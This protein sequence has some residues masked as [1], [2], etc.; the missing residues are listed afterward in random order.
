MLNASWDNCSVGWLERISWTP[1][2]VGVVT[3]LTILIVLTVAGN[4]LV[5]AA[6]GKKRRLRSSAGLLILSLATADL[7]VGVLILPF[8]AAHELMGF[9]W[10]FGAIPCQL[11]LS[12][13]I[14][15]CTASI[16]NLVVISIDR[17][18]AIIKPL[19]YPLIV[20][21]NRAKMI[22]LA[23]YALSFA[24][25]LPSFIMNWPNADAADRCSCSPMGQTPL[26]IIYSSSGSFF[27]PMA[28]VVFVYLRIYCAAL[29]ATQSIVSGHLASTATATT[30]SGGGN[31]GAL[32]VHRGGASEAARRKSSTVLHCSQM[33]RAR[34]LS[35]GHTLDN[36]LSVSSAA[37]S[38]GSARSSLVDS[39]NPPIGG[40]RSLN[41]AQMWK[42]YRTRLN[43]N[44]GYQKRLSSEIKAAKTVAIVT[45][46]FIVCWLGFAVIYAMGALPSCQQNAQCVSATTF[47]V[48]F[49]LG[50][51]NS[52]LNPIIYTLFNRQFRAA[53]KELLG[54]RQRADQAVVWGNGVVYSGLVLPANNA[55][56]L[57]LR[58]PAAG[59]YME[60][61][62]FGDQ[63]DLDAQ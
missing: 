14:W 24:I 19:N 51:L 6:I 30:G 4:C 46:C 2:T 59:I 47:S 56:T 21:K 49:W 18:I 37:S 39:L 52:C 33:S 54:C 57:I 17:Y 43:P 42:N 36:R 48:F 22:V 13:D 11:W 9:Y 7:L 31:G 27:I 32:R 45:G 34:T 15:L 1:W 12:V 20:T 44:V 8:S 62:V 16:Y 61:T 50:Y 53:F 60:C 10:P 29:R 41:L 23:V 5:I 38:S 35:R 55:T 26:Y 58:S 28:I 25:C 3:S 40:K 63:P